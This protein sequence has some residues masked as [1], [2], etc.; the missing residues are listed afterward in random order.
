[1]GEGFKLVK[2]ILVLL[3]EEDVDGSTIWIYCPHVLKSY[4]F[5]I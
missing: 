4:L 3:T 2:G 1:M 5:T